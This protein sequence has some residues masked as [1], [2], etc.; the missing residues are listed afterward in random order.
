MFCQKCDAKNLEEAS[1]C[2]LCGTRIQNLSETNSSLKTLEIESDLTKYVGFWLRLGAYILD[3]IIFIVPFF[4]LTLVLS[5][6]L[7]HFLGIISWWLYFSISESSSK[8]ATFGKRIV[9]IKV[10]DVNG[11]KLSFGRATGRHFSK[12]LSGIFLGIG[13]IMAAFTEKN[14]ALHDLIVESFVIKK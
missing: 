9:G 2:E 1:F 6:A 4:L 10:V 11:N 5:E 14:Q 3:Y 7:L 12:V 8:Q 13:F